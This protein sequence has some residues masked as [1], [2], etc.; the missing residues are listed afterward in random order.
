MKCKK[1]EKTF[2]SI[3]VIDGRKRNLSNRKYCFEC[4]PFG[5]HNT[6]RLHLRGDEEFRICLKCERKY[7]R[8]S[9]QSKGMCGSCYTS[10]F[11]IRLK[12]EIVDIFG[13][14]CQI[15]GY[16]SCINALEFHHLDPSKKETQISGST[17]NKQ[18]LLK[19][20]EK[21]ILVCNRCHR[22]IHSGVVQ[23][24]NNRLLIDKS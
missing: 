12:R 23:W 2:S 19:E 16:S 7:P 8:S 3:V 5:K 13:G 20:V 14:S 4:S 17:K 22:E 9:K 15:C 21:C 18:M 10:Q 6:K 1:C 24:Q 11:R